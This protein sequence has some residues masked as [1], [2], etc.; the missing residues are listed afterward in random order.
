M[1]QN[2]QQKI[3]QYKKTAQ[4]NLSSG[5]R[6]VSSKSVRVDSLALVI[7]SKKDAENGSS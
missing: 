2:I 6:S 5:S 4:R 3:D 7:R 1:N